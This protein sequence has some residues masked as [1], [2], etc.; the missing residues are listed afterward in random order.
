M[1]L[2]DDLSTLLSKAL[3]TDGCEVTHIAVSERQRLEAWFEWLQMLSGHGG[4]RT[5]RKFKTQLPNGSVVRFAVAR[6]TE[7]L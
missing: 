2:R 7:K 5:I 1:N 6:D 4:V 3:V